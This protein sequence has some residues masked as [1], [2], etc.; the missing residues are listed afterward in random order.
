[1]AAVPT[2]VPNIRMDWD[3]QP[4]E[5]R[6]DLTRGAWESGINQ[7]LTYLYREPPNATS[8]AVL[9][10]YLASGRTVTIAPVRSPLGA[11]KIGRNASADPTSPERATAPGKETE[12]GKPGSVGVGGGSDTVIRFAAQ[13][14][15]PVTATEQLAIT[16]EVLLH[17]IVHALRQ[18]SGQED[19]A[20]LTSPFPQLSK[21]DGSV[22]ELMSGTTK[23]RENKYSQIYNNLE[24]FV[25]ILVTNIYRSENDRPGLVRDHVSDKA[26]VWP[27]TNA[28]NFMTAWRPQITRLCSEMPQLCDRLAAIA[29]HFNP[30]FELYA[31]QN[32]FLPGGRA[33]RAR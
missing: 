31:A 15:S 9:S 26:L 5:P 12:T 32:R 16:D 7:T 19:N 22:S 11:Q 18:A 33:V 6:T 4:P 1:M 14:W 24:E 28:R 23:D 25:A 17:E 13:D 27:L 2:I 20:W 29:C 30:I 21:G 3:D 8:R 10:A